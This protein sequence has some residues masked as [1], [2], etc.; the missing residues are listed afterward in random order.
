M[1]ANM[2]WAKKISIEWYKFAVGDYFTTFSL[3]VSVVPPGKPVVTVPDTIVL[4]NAV[5]LTCT[6][7]GGN[8]EPTVKWFKDGAEITTGVS[9]KTVSPSTNSYTVTSTLNFVA[10]LE[11]HLKVITCQA[12]NGLTSP[13]STTEQLIVN[14]KLLKNFLYQCCSMS[15]YNFFF[16]SRLQFC[17]NKILVPSIMSIRSNKFEM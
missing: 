4:G 10:S 3:F 14:C 16:N 13:L 9:S 2:I 1:R 15:C 17:R 12:D 8:P 6:S 7:N 5:T 11:H